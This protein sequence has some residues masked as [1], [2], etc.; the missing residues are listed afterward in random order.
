MIWVAIYML[1]L[2]IRS[3]RMVRFLA[4][5]DDVRIGMVKTDIAQLLV[6]HILYAA[7]LCK[8]MVHAQLQERINSG[9]LR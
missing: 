8:S 7:M 2:G 1:T 6:F 3:P 4:C 9:N 5:G